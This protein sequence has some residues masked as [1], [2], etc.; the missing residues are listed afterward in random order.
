[1]DNLVIKTTDSI[2]ESVVSAFKTIGFVSQATTKATKADVGRG[3]SYYFSLKRGKRTLRFT[4]LHNTVFY[5]YIRDCSRGV[6]TSLIT[7]VSDTVVI[8]IKGI[9]D[10]LAAMDDAALEIVEGRKLQAF[11]MQL[12]MPYIQGKIEELGYQVSKSTNDGKKGILFDFK[13]DI[14]VPEKFTLLSIPIKYEE[15]N[16]TENFDDLPFKL[17]HGP[18]SWN[19]IPIFE[20]TLGELFVVVKA[21]KEV[22]AEVKTEIEEALKVYKEL[23]AQIAALQEKAKPFQR[24]L[25]SESNMKIAKLKAIAKAS[26]DKK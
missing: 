16:K 9:N 13:E 19:S 1:M 18:N 14:R 2:V 21:Y 8:D 4:I 6:L 3:T 26:K 15:L 12:I 23:T 11:K 10:K 17:F 22:T 24:I 25:H 7:I 5:L 20:G